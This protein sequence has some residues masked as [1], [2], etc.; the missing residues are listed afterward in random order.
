MVERPE[1]LEGDNLSKQQDFTS[2]VEQ[3]YRKPQTHEELVRNLRILREIPE[4]VS[5][6]KVV[7]KL[8]SPERSHKFVLM[9]DE[10]GRLYLIA[11][12]IEKMGFH[13]EIV[14]FAERL[15][16][17]KFEILGG[18][19]IYTEGEK[20]IIADSSGSYGEAPKNLVR[21]ILRKKFPDLEIETLP[22]EFIYDDVE[23]SKK[24]KMLD[25]AIGKLENPFLVDFY[26]YVLEKAVRLGFDYTKLPE[27]I[28]GREDL[29][30][31]I[32]SS[33]NGVSFG[34]ETLY[35]GYK[36]KDGK[37]MVKA[38]LIESGY[39]HISQVY[40]E[41]NNVHFKYRVGDEEKELTIPLD[42]IEEFETII[43]LDD[44]DKQ[45]FE[46]YESNQEVFRDA[47]IYHGV[48]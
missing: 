4:D 8:G 23:E 32:Y 34:F 16:G 15:Y 22:A 7:I 46:M 11:L 33:D 40:V 35:L 39:I 30:Y 29:A 31:M 6:P 41:G 10:E 42:K 2:K 14:Y 26:L 27:F 1:G 36:D 45:L 25:E 5:D 48:G 37:V 18:G 47:M 12:P 9:K 38:I 19:Y 13:A 43:N 17:K 28:P 21:H 44:I 20:L 3:F 24:R